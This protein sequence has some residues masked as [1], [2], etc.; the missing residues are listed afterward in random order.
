MSELCMERFDEIH[1]HIGKEE[2][3]VTETLIRH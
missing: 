2:W 3:P 1:D